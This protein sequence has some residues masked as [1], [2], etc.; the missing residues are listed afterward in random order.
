MI[1]RL[2]RP[3]IAD[4]TWMEE[5][6]DLFV[7]GFEWRCDDN[8]WEVALEK[9]HSLRGGHGVPRL[10]TRRRCLPRL[11]TLCDVWLVGGILTDESS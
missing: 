8:D 10:R 4:R 7:R 2:D 3:R 9:V 1:V 6:D 5:F 11:R